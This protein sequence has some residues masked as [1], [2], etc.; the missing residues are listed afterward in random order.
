MIDTAQKRRSALSA[1]GW[2]HILPLPSGMVDQGD[3]QDVLW[4]YRGILAA[5]PVIPPLVNYVA[6]VADL[7]QYV[8]TV[9]G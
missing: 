5:Q 1:G 2:A 7:G 4:I 6:T 3:Q 8:A 9:V